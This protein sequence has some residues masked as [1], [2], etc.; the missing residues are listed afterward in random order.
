MIY[1]LCKHEKHENTYVHPQSMQLGR[2]NL[3][4]RTTIGA[5]VPLSVRYV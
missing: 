2:H 3:L 1:S 4:A 5:D